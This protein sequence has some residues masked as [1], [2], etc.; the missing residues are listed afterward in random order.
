MK[1]CRFVTNSADET[2]ELAGRLAERFQPG[3]VV[4]LEGDLGAGKTTFSQGVAK[5]LGIEESID[6]PT[7]TLIKEYGEGRLPF[8]HMDVYRLDSPDEELGWDEYFYGDG[9]TLVEWAE[10]IQNWL[11]DRLI[12]VAIRHLESG[13]REITVLPPDECEERICRGG[14]A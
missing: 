8:Y 9:V 2:R 13:G 5:G 11:P 7:F 4:A 12:R 10:R 14:K 3:D 1:G 6:S